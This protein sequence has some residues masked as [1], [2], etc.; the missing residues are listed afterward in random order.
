MS[1]NINMTDWDAQTSASSAPTS[2]APPTTS[3]SAPTTSSTS[4][5]SSSSTS[6]SQ[7]STWTP[8]PVTSVMTVTGG[9]QT[10][11]ITPTAP[12]PSSAPVTQKP[13]STFFNSAGKVAGLFVGLAVIILLTAA[14]I[15]LWC[16]RRRH[17]ALFAPGSH[18]T[19]G[20]PPRTRSRSMSELGLISDDKDTLGSKS[21][22]RLSTGMWGGAGVSGD[23][24]TSPDRR[25]SNAR[26][27]DQR[28]DPG[29]LWNPIHD[30]SSR[31]SVR[32]L[33]DDRDYSRRVLRL[34]NPDQ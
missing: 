32:S 30:N 33:Q 11:T 24:P 17:P 26:I 16:W 12:P 27:V 2:T 14:G 23:S 15:L 3:F 10:V 4:S 6:S 8:T 25:S 9:L 5:T 19:G 21:L 29:T 13:T 31:V 28:L 20:S 1:P 34:A 18:T 22:P 7:T